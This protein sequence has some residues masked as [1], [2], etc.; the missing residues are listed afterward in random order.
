MNQVGRGFVVEGSLPTSLSKPWHPAK[1]S[2]WYN[3]ISGTVETAAPSPPRPSTTRGARPHRRPAVSGG[4]RRPPRKT[5]PRWAGEAALL[6]P[7]RV[8]AGFRPARPRSGTSRGRTRDVRTRR[9]QSPA[10]QTFQVRSPRLRAVGRGDLRDCPHRRDTCGA[11]PPRRPPAHL[12]DAVEVV[13][14]V[15]DAETQYQGQ[16][17]AG[18][19]EPHANLALQVEG[20]LPGQ[21]L[22]VHRTRGS[23]RHD[24]TPRLPRASPPQRRG[25]RREERRRSWRPPPLPLPAARSALQ[26]RPGTTPAAAAGAW[27][28]LGGAGVGLGGSPARRGLFSNVSGVPQ[29]PPWQCYRHRPPHDR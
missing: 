3:C 13:A 29:P 23:A 15:G 20:E 18:A 8:R 28:R 22:P 25:R 17:H 5:Q 2:N 6:G 19:E 26:R 9:P 21:H 10:L 24:T 16:A 4:R 11:R 1:L 14:G 7:C 12:G 27:H